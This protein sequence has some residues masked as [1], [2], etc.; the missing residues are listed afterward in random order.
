[1]FKGKECSARCKNSLN[2][3]KRQASA[4]KLEKCYCDGTED[5]DCVNIKTNMEE[6]CYRETNE[7]DDEKM[8]NKSGST[9]S[10]WIAKA[11]GGSLR[12]TP[13]LQFVF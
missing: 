6:L 3:L 10:A 13:G 8:D 9:S 4:S 2:I 7:I 11:E 1:M 12:E 5:F